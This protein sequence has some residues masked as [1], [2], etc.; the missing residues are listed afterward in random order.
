MSTDERS[1]EDLMAAYVDGD[2]RALRELF[3][4]MRRA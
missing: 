2:Q 4:A 1:D 3:I